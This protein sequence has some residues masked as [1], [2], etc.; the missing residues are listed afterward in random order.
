MI[1]PSSLFFETEKERERERE[2]REN[3][4][5]IYVL[6][7]KERQKL[8]RL[9]RRG[10]NGKRKG[11]FRYQKRLKEKRGMKKCNDEREREM[12]NEDLCSERTGSWILLCQMAVC[13]CVFE[14]ESQRVSEREREKWGKE[15]GESIG[16]GLKNM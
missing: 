11:K 10:R 7:K 14:R 8:K 5:E 15:R 1:P 4:G 3:K 12:K 16:E 9:K 2:R 13:V 6:G